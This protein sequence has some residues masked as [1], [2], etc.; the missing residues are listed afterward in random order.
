MNCDVLIIGGGLEGLLTGYIFNRQ[1]TKVI[2]IDPLG[3][4]AYQYEGMSDFDCEFQSLIKYYPEMFHLDLF[5]L[6]LEAQYLLMRLVEDLDDQCEYTRYPKLDYQYTEPHRF[7][8]P[9]NT[10][11]LSYQSAMKL[12][13]QK[14]YQAFIKK[15]T[16][17]NIELFEKEEITDIVLDDTTINITTKTGRIIETN[18]LIFTNRKESELFFDKPAVNTLF[19]INSYFAEFMDNEVN[20]EG[21]RTSLNCRLTLV[22]HLEDKNIFYHVQSD[23]EVIEENA[24]Y[25]ATDEEYPNIAYNLTNNM[26]LPT[27]IGALILVQNYVKQYEYEEEKWKISI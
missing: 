3:C 15:I 23:L 8:F 20:L 27:L 17:Y 16:D 24:P 19:L 5:Q 21:K 13:P 1:K 7:L 6:N 2:I 11:I 26:I 25:I 12:N 14:L 18:K 4:D 10:A 22:P 9:I